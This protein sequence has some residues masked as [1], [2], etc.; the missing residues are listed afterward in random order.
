MTDEWDLDWWRKAQAESIQRRGKTQ[1]TAPTG[2]TILVVTEGT[3]TEPIYFEALRDALRLSAVKI[4]IAFGNTSA[5]LSVVQTAANKAQEQKRKKGRGKLGISE[6]EKFDQVWAVIDTD[7]A[8]RDGLWQEVG[9]AAKKHRV[10]LA[11]STPSFEF[12]LLLHLRYCTPC[13]Q[14]SAHAEQRLEQELGFTYN[15]K[16]GEVQRVIQRVLPT[17]PTAVNN[18]KKVREHHKECG[19]VLP[20]DPSTDVD[21]MVWAFNLAAALP[22]RRNLT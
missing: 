10:L 20:A 7:A 1:P 3:V 19:T 6:P 16:K 11:H 13:L 4:V 18:A 2:D 22:Y 21:L 8:V 12:W 15:K 14:S 5:P 17:W 9:A